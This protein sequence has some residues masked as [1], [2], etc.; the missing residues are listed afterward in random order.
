MIL[1]KRS[2]GSDAE[3]WLGGR[4]ETGVQ[5]GGYCSKSKELLVGE[6]LMQRHSRMNKREPNG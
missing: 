4:V 6:E 5:R 2:P 1:Q 3:N